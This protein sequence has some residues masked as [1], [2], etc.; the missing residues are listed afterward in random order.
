MFAQQQ[1]PTKL[2]LRGFG[3][4]AGHNLHPP[5]VDAVLRGAGAV[6]RGY[7]D[8]VHHPRRPTGRRARTVIRTF[9]STFPDFKF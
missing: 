9:V 3:T 1:Q 7:A 2:G 4:V 6:V 5:L 8:P